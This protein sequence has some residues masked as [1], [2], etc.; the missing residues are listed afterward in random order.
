MSGMVAV[1]IAVLPILLLAACGGGSGTDGGPGG[2]GGA[3]ECGFAGDDY[4]PYAAGYTWTYR[5]TDLATG[6]RATKEQRLDP[7]QESDFGPVLVQVTGKLNGETVSL[8]RKE[9]DRV[10]RFQQEDRDAAGAVERTTVYDPPAIRIDES[11]VRVEAGAAWD[12]SYSETITDAAGT[13]T[14]DTVDHWEVIA[15]GEACESPLGTFECLRVRRTRT[16]GGVA[17]KEFSFA[18]GIGKIREVGSDQ[19]EEL[20][21]CG[22][23]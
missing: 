18:R 4:L 5:I 6:E 2:D 13:V 23:E 8:V 3:G 7:E 12:E 1:R 17:E 9:G 15:V 11:P 16:Q 14:I 20:S 22:P 21:A 19:L 10:L